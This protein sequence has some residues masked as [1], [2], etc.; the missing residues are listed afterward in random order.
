MDAVAK[1]ATKTVVMPLN[2]PPTFT[3]PGETRVAMTTGALA[4]RLAQLTAN[5]NGR[6]TATLANREALATSRGVSGWFTRDRSWSDYAD[7]H[8]ANADEAE[9]TEVVR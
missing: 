4:L 8:G 1:P 3:V 5:A 9:V 2:V 7:K 6:G